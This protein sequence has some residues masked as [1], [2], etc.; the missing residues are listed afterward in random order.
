MGN[1]VEVVKLDNGRFAKPCPK[2]GRVQDYLRKNYAEAS[3]R[4]G[5]L[6]KKC[7]QN[8]PTQNGVMLYRGIRVSW[9]NKFRTGAILR[10]LDWDI[11]LDYIADLYEQQDRKCALTGWELGFPETGSIYN[12]Y[13]SL[14]RI[15]SDFGYLRDNVQIVDKRV[16]MMKQQYSQ[17]EFIMIC[18]A[19]SKNHSDSEE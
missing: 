7:V 1:A 18:K 11:D 10:N 4:E 8:D 15:N 5:K 2:C 13:A 9:F 14:D 12:S 19:V 6:C 3:M 16:N 17:E